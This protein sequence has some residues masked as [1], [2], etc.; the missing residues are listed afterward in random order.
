MKKIRVKII[1]A[2]IVVTILPAFPIS[3]A[4]NKILDSIVKIGWNDIE[5]SL[6]EGVEFS[7]KYYNSEKEKLYFFSKTIA[8][9]SELQESLENQD[10]EKFSEK[11]FGLKEVAIFNSQKQ[12]IF[13][14]GLENFESSLLETD[15]TK[16]FP[17]GSKNFLVSVSSL[18]NGNFLVLGMELDGNFEKDS[19]HTLDVLKTF[20]MLTNKQDDVTLRFF[21][22]F[23]VIYVSIVLVSFLVASFLAKKIVSPIKQLVETTKRISAGDLG[24]RVK[25][26]SNDEIGT[27]ENSMNFMLDQIKHEHDKVLNLEKM[28]AWREIAR[29]L[30]HE[31]KNPLT[32]IQ[33]TIQE[34]KDRYKGD[35]LAFKKFLENCVEIIT[36]E[37]NSLKTLVNEFSEFARSPKLELTLGNLNQLVSDTIQLYQNKNISLTCEEGKNFYFDSDKI[38]RCLI[39]LLQNAILSTKES[40]G[41]IEILVNYS[42]DFAILK[43]KDNGSGIPKENLEKIFEPHFTTRSTGMGLG[44]AIVKGIVDKHEGKI[45]VESEVGKGSEF[46]IFLKLKDEKM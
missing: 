12:K 18:P 43:V 19:E 10:F 35:D 26:S 1:L 23:L 14:K 16:I 36:E 32:P 11:V 34:L 20:Q 22:A 37:V 41:K 24:L 42:D 44:L 38:K 31:I 46:R 8:E 39:N 6:G 17:Y 40:S 21:S 2:F 33:L 29:G 7:K 9:S 28:S 4:V 3:I 13:S 5:K 45:E 30:A 25:V 27:L 15:S